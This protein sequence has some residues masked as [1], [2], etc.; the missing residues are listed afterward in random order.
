VRRTK[1]LALIAPVA[2]AALALSACGSSGG[3][4]TPGGTPGGTTGTTG[5]APSGSA[6]GAY[7]VQPVTGSGSLT[8]V[9]EKDITDFNTSTSEGN[10]FDAGQV[11]NAIYPQVFLVDPTFKPY[12]NTDFVKSA[13]LTSSS[14]QVVTYQLQPNVKWSDGSPITVDDFMFSW[15]AQSGKNKKYTPASTTG[16]EDISTITATGTPA[17]GQTITVTFATPYPDW[18]GLFSGSNSA[19]LPSKQMLALENGDPVAAYNKAFLAP[20]FPKVSGG[21]YTIT[22]FQPGQSVTLTR[23][24]AYYGKKAGL[25]QIIWRIITDAAQEPQALQNNEV[26]YIY[27]Q[28][29]VDLVSQV[30]QISGVNTS[31]RNGLQFEHI[32]FNLKNPQL[33]QLPLRRAMFLATNRDQI[34]QGTVKQ[35]D[36]DAKPLDN[37][38]L[39]PGQDGFQSNIA[40]L[41]GGSV[42]E[43]KKA[44]TDA[45]YKGVGTALMDP[46][47]KPVGP[48]TFKYTEGNLIRQRTGEIFASQMKPLG[49]TVTPTAIPSLG[50]TLDQ[51]DF[52]IIVFAW[53]ATPFPY[54]A[55]AALY[56]TGG[57]SNYPGYSNPDVDKA[58]ND[59][60]SNL[61]PKA[62]QADLNAADLQISKDAATL[63]LYQKPTFLAVRDN[64]VNIFNNASSAGPS[65]NI[66]QWGIKT[67]K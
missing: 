60:K 63:P 16:Y 1:R 53:V 15:Q 34:I 17:A 43:A 26:Q 14:P 38:M 12:L 39:V 3:G 65:N 2:G 7:A 42:D 27:P 64:Y 35:F 19:V 29:Q 18:K 67:A 45:G 21:P 37:R 47:G 66:G 61:D 41:G 25:D 11:T 56:V 52:Q 24:D 10:V 46:Q 36:P 20:N 32:D 59:A 57:D 31:I 6:S 4:G 49:I 13:D 58:L 54:S 9:I 48:F 22:A 8:A 30:K 23:N 40:G 33:S 62:A 50:K 28:P 55:N 44:L 51:R 5:A